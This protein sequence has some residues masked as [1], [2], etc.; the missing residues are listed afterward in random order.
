MGQIKTENCQ[1][2]HSAMF[3]ANKSGRHHSF[4]IPGFVPESALFMSFNKRHRK[5]IYSTPM[6][7]LKTYIKLVKKWIVYTPRKKCW[8][9]WTVSLSTR[10][11]DVSYKQECP[12]SQTDVA[13]FC[14]TDSIVFTEIVHYYSCTSTS[15]LV[16][17]FLLNFNIFSV[18]LSR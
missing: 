3:M 14:F 11:S 2:I 15:S 17:A 13:F 6:K 12:R 16:N 5:S 10:Y 18:R 4:N 7:N 9:T 8:K 1:L